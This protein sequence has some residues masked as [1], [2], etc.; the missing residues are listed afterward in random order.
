MLHAP[1]VA[2]RVLVV[3]HRFFFFAVHVFKLLR[4]SCFYVT[5]IHPLSFLIPQ[6]IYPR[7]VLVAAVVKN[8]VLLKIMKT[9]KRPM[10]KTTVVSIKILVVERILMTVVACEKIAEIVMTAIA[11]KKHILL[12]LRYRRL[13]KSLTV[14]EKIVPTRGSR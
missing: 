8:I 6:V 13:K 1:F 7:I 3:V 5:Y 12:C 11:V 4:H 14:I 10:V 2:A 9:Y